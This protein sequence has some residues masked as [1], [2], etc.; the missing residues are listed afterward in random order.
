[1]PNKKYRTRDTSL[2]DDELLILDVMFSGGVTAPMLRRSYFVAQWNAEP[3]TLDDGALQETLD[4]LLCNGI[5]AQTHHQCRGYHYLRM[6]Q[7]GGEVWSAE[8]CPIWERYCTERYK[9]TSRGRTLMSVTAVS[10]EIRDD[11]LQLWPEYPARRRSKSIRD[12]G[13]IEWRPFDAIHIGLA[14][15]DE[16][17]EWACDDYEQYLKQ[18]QKYM[19]RIDSG[20]TWWRTVGELQRFVNARLAG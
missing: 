2:T 10:A 9:T 6:T 19:Q 3:H 18:H 13:L 12:F 1:M 7:V 4:R 20:R 16:P 17:K 5:I 15:Y 14:T 8:R 11:F